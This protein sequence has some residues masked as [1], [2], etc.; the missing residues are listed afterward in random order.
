MNLNVLPNEFNNLDSNTL[1]HD[2]I[3]DIVTIDNYKII[4]KNLAYLDDIIYNK[5]KEKEIAWCRAIK[6]TTYKELDKNLIIVLS[7]RERKLFLR[8][9]KKMNSDNFLYEYWKNEDVNEYVRQSEIKD[10]EEKAKKEGFDNGKNY[11]ANEFIKN[12]LLNGAGLKFIS[13]VSGKSKEEIKSL[14]K[15]F[16]K[17]KKPFII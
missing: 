6:A 3:N 7:N 10:A 17:T 4:N 5:N 2:T 16:K 9:V 15:Q 8:E 1:L 11:I 12:M 13:K 14:K